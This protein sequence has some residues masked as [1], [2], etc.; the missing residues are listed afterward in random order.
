METEREY[1]RRVTI[2]VVAGGHNDGQPKA[3]TSRP[4]LSVRVRPNES[5]T[6]DNLHEELVR[7]R[8]AGIR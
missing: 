1:H 6:Q 7:E 2:K 4:R 8:G 5:L 3:V